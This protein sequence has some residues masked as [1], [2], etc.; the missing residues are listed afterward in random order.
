MLVDQCE[1]SLAIWF[2]AT[3]P[4]CHFVFPPEYRSFLLR[5]ALRHEQPPAAADF[6]GLWFYPAAWRTRLLPSDPGF[7]HMVESE[8]W[9]E[10]GF[11]GVGSAQYL[12]CE[13]Q[14]P[15]FGH[16]GEFTD[17]VPTV[18]LDPSQAAADRMRRAHGGGSLWDLETHPIAEYVA[19]FEEYLHE[20]FDQMC[21][22]GYEHLVL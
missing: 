16:A 19:P 4:E 13:R 11:R 1:A 14:S 2:A 18:L 12:C 7:G 22:L 20:K 3:M 8:A 15:L 17:A 5:L 9:L 10:I 21:E 6:F